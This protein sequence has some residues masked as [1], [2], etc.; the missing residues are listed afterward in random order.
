MLFCLHSSGTQTDQK[1]SLKWTAMAP[2][3]GEN[4][5][6]SVLNHGYPDKRSDAIKCT[7][8]SMT[9][10]KGVSPADPNIQ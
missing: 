5:E 3:K 9:V 2:R 8:A 7:I 10:G 1:L 4:Y 6:L